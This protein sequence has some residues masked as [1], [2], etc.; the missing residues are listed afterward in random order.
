MAVFHFPPSQ[1]HPLFPITVNKCHRP[2]CFAIV[3]L[4][5]HILTYSEVPVMIFL[6]GRVS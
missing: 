5:L 1:A 2:T 3:D 4:S 6:I